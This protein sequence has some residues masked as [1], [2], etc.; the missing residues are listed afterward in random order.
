M[1]Q[2]AWQSR[3]QPPTHHCRPLCRYPPA[4]HTIHTTG[5]MY[6][7]YF[8]KVRHAV[9]LPR[10]RVLQKA[11][12]TN[13]VRL[14]AP[15]VTTSGG[16]YA[17]GCCSCDLIC[18]EVAADSWE[19]V[20]ACV[21]GNKAKSGPSSTRNNTTQH[22]AHRDPASRLHPGVWCSHYHDAAAPATRRR[23]P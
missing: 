7:P 19:E 22:C 3:A 17:L 12:H 20:R 23:V 18:G 1:H 5:C 8:M 13:V 14:S 11:V 2:A 16:R 21:S 4:T 9:D 10:R 6:K 15:N